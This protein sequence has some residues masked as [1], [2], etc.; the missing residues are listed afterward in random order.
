M[1][2]IYPERFEPEAVIL[3]S[4]DYPSHPIPSAMLHDATRVVCCDSAAFEYVR[5]EGLPW[6]IVGDCD[7][8]L[9]PTTD[10]ERLIL[11]R[12]RHLIIHVAEQ[13][14]N[15]LTKAVRH[16][17]ELGISRLAIVGATGQREDHTLGNISLLIE[18]MRMGI[19]VRMY[20][21][22]GIFIPCSGDIECHVPI[23]KGFMAD[24]DHNARRMKSTQISIFNISANRYATCGLRYPFA[25]LGNWWEGTLNEAVTSPFS[26]QADGEYLL[27]INYLK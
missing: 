9:S 13:D 26:I 6:C 23:P 1:Q 2:T 11:E 22:H 14:S 18:Y 5:R 4:G 24:D 16:C 25:H 20:T 19:D 3:C 12:C 27:F 17:K 21:D 10:D 15:D 8:I 7:S